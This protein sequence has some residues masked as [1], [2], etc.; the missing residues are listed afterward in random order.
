TR[1]RPRLVATALPACR[2]RRHRPRHPARTSR[3]PVARRR[4]RLVGGGRLH[5]QPRPMRRAAQRALGYLDRREVTIV[6]ALTL[7]VDCIEPAP[8]KPGLETPPPAAGP[9]RL[10]AGRRRRLHVRRAAFAP[11]DPY[12]RRTPAI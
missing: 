1:P 12:R 9:R 7:L 2:Q 10:E 11:Q 3:R 8:I 5:R 6:G 4:A